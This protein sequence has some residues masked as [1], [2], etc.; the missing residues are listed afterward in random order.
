MVS[1]RREDKCITVKLWNM[2]TPYIQIIGFVS[3]LAS[4]IFFAGGSWNDVKAYSKRIDVIEGW[5]TEEQQDMAVIKQ[6]IKDIH[7][8]LL[9]RK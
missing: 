7:D 2:A 3:T 8:Y 9:P 1:R 4:I 6:Q 5:K